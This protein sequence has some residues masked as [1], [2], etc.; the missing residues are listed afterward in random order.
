MGNSTIHF[1]KRKPAAVEEVAP[2][3]AP[4]EVEAEV[5]SEPVVDEE[6]VLVN[7]V[8]ADTVE[9]AEAAVPAGEAFMAPEPMTPPVRPTANVATP[10]PFAEAALTNGPAPRKEKSGLSWF[11]RMRGVSKRPEKRGDDVQ[12]EFAALREAGAES[13]GEGNAP[14][15]E[16]G[17]KKLDDQLEIPTFLRRQAN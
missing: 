8:A 5:E 6:L 2:A 15:A 14:S 9:Q 4:A 16:E 10:D 7:E 17:R 3:S 1:I 13:D 12:P 11:D